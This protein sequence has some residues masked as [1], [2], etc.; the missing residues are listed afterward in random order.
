MGEGQA[1]AAMTFRWNCDQCVLGPNDWYE[2]VIT[3]VD[4]SG[5][6]R[7]VAGRTQDKFLSLRRIIEGGQYD[8]Y[9]KAKDGLYQWYVQVKHE[10]GNQPLTPPSEVWK[11]TWL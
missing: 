9:Q 2:V 4:K 6:P 8:I 3:Y 1:N 10:P 7:T 11:F 5:V